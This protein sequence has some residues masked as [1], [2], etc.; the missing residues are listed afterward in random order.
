MCLLLLSYNIDKNYKLI[1]AGNRDEYYNRPAKAL[2]FWQDYPG[3]LAGRDLKGGGTWLGVGHSGRIAAITNYRNPA[4]HMDDAP[5]RGHLVSDYLAGAIP[6]DR[7]LQY[8]KNRAHLYNGFNLITGSGS[9]LFYY[10]NR[11][12]GIKRLKPG[13]YGLSN[14][15]LDTPWPKVKKGKAEF[16]KILAGSEKINTEDI[17]SIL[18]DTSR[19]GDAELPVTGAGIKGERIL[20]SIFII[21]D[22]YGTRSSSIVLQDRQGRTTFY[23]RTYL[24]KKSRVTGNETVILKFE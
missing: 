3:I 18:C 10:S 24:I 12:G 16:E 15:L 22:I 14:H 4:L 21:S 7:Y 17:F 13:L 19:P 9:E 1:V 5:S 20:S 6:A 8:I 23:E 11:G 2:G